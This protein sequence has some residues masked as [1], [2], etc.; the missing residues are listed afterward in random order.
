MKNKWIQLKN[1]GEIYEGADA[2]DYPE[3]PSGKE[4][5][6]YYN[7]DWSITTKMS[8]DDNYTYITHEF[9]GTC[10]VIRLEKGEI[11]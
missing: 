1:G 5:G 9:G 4:L 3:T 11:K 10:M 8:E 7:N 2:A 6:H